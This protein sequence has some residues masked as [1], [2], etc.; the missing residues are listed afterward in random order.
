MPLCDADCAAIYKVLILGDAS[1][2]KTALLR[3]L[4]GRDF[5]AKLLPTIGNYCHKI[6]NSF[7]GF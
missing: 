5:Q 7:N 1:V 4:T 6:C 3:S 2:G